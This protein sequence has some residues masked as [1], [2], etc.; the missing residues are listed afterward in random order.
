MG[1]P[2][3][4]RLGRNQFW[5]KKWF[6]DWSYSHTFKMVNTFES[7]ITTYLNY[8]FFFTK[9]IFFYNYWH[10]NLLQST[11][12]NLNDTQHLN[13]YYRRYYY[14]HKTLS[15]EH[16]YL[17]RVNTPE[18]FPLRTYFIKYLNWL[19]VSVQWFKPAKSNNTKIFF[20]KNNNLRLVTQGI[21][22]KKSFF[23]KSNNNRFRLLV[24]L[25]SNVLSISSINYSF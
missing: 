18:Y 14:S 12:F 2:V 15:I 22:T 17:L 25:L 3:I 11:N 19:I 1:N 6:N 23:K 4:T 21:S 13:T 7:I 10:K 9:N 8:G 5:Y 20:R 24:L 16:T